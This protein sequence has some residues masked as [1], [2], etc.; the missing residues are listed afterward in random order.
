MFYSFQSSQNEDSP[1]QR[2]AGNKPAKGLHA[3][4]EC[5]LNLAA[6]MT[7]IDSG[8]SPQREFSRSFPRI[9]KTAALS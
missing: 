9:Y 1:L 8:S 5:A 6:S 7:T 3:C 4:V 2:S